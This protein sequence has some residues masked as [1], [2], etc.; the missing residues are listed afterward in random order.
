M[1]L[2][3]YVLNTFEIFTETVEVQPVFYKSLVLVLHYY[4]ILSDLIFKYEQSDLPKPLY[5]VLWVLLFLFLN[6]YSFNPL[7]PG[8][9][10]GRAYL[11]KPPA[12]SSMLV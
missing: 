6:L 4:P 3:R 1:N 5:P 10:R 9:G 2:N 12:F 8:G 7:V 11:K